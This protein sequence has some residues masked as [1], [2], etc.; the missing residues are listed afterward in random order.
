MIHL[1]EAGRSHK[2]FGVHGKLRIQIDDAYKEF[3]DESGVLFIRLEGN[4][5]PFFIE[6]LEEDGDTLVKFK[7]V[8]SPEE[9]RLLSNQLLYIDRERY[10]KSDAFAGEED[11]V[12]GMELEHYTLI[13]ETSGVQAEIIHIEEFPQQLMVVVQLHQKDYFVPVRDEWIRSL[14]H[15]EK[16]II[17]QLPAGIFD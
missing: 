6:H 7:E 4:D 2:V 3:V 14:D 9:A 13:D 10:R 16:K 17:M 8:D 15:D 12:S 5:V 11:E 1:I